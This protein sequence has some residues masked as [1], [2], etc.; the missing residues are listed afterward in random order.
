MNPRTESNPELTPVA[1]DLCGSVTVRELYTA[2]DRLR[3]TDLLFSIAECVGCGVLRTLPDMSDAELAR[4]YPDD[5]WGGAGP[6]QKWIES[7]QSE[8]T[9]LSRRTSSRKRPRIR[10]YANAIR[11]GRLNI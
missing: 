10:G 3:N 2:K 6:S 9:R 7:S 11:V 5:Y 4:Y 8:K 1:C